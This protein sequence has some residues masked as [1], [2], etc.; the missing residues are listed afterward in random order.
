MSR[1]SRVLQDNGESSLPDFFIGGSSHLVF[2]IYCHIVLRISERMDGNGH[3]PFEDMPSDVDFIK[4]H[5]ITEDELE[6][7]ERGL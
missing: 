6:D 1:F 4:R 5:E 7:A 3:S 2:A